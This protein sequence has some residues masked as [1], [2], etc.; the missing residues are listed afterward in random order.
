MDN[1]H[2]L[3]LAIALLMFPQLAQTLYSPALAD[4]VQHFAVAPGLAA[5]TLTVYFLSFA[6]GVIGW[7]WLSDRCGRRVAMLA[8]LAFYAAATVIALCV[9]TFQGLLFAQAFAAFGA[10]VGSVV[11]QTI[12]RDC[13]AGAAL[14][15]VFAV[16][17][18]VLALSPAI[19]LFAGAALVHAFGYRGVLWCL[20]VLAMSLL[21]WSA[22]AL[23]ETR[24]RAMKN[25]SL[26]ETFR[27]LMHNAGVWR[28][29]LLVTVFNVAMY[30]YYA[31]G[32]FIF[33]R[34]G[35]NESAYGASGILLAAGSSL[36]SWS[37]RAFARAGVRAE[38][39]LMLSA[40]LVLGGGLG[41]RALLHSEWFIA[42]TLLVVFA[43]GLAIPHVLGKALSAFG[44]RLGT[45]GALFGLMYYLMIGAGMLLTGWGQS[46]GNTL[47]VCGGIA[48]L[49]SI[50]G[51][52]GLSVS[53]VRLG[54]TDH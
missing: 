4:F 23:P 51:R 10:A 8:G 11:T 5:Q 34:L 12:L 9:T 47:L 3:P 30:G 53:P 43:F 29:A 21:V 41:V 48:L 37:N 14:T 13:F 16:V 15:K 49:L 27:L 35:L 17:G 28:S 32:P 54:K 2:F 6:F 46:L 38:N 24:S 33:Q 40:V 52:D 42:P 18:M 36:G 25:V 44:D 31:L 20:L 1:K 39:L 22:V 26:R 50:S 7:G 45:A 19:G